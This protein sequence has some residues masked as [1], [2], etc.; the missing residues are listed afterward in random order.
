MQFIGDRSKPTIGI[1]RSEDVTKISSRATFPLLEKG[2]NLSTALKEACASVGGSGG[3]H[4]I[5]SGGTCPIE[6][7]E[8]FLSNLD[9]IVGKQLS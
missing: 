2:V 9:K 3:G 8:E 6:R 1:N 7:S 4:K 5:A